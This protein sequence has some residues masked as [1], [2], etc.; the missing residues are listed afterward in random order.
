MGARRSVCG[1]RSVMHEKLV[2][3]PRKKSTVKKV[4]NML[5]FVLACVS[6][7]LAMF[8]PIIF[9]IPAVI[10][11]ALWYFQSF[12]GDIEYEYTYFDGEFRFAKIKAKRKRK[13]LGMVSMEDVITIAP[14]GDRSV[15]KYENDSNLTYK[16]LTSG[17][18]GA[19]VYELVFKGEKGINRYEIEPDEDMLDEVMVKYPRIVIK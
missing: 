6:F 7:V 14:K 12:R 1:K 19:K 17:D 2:I 9:L 16:D 11:A 5:W 4:L 3:V 18:S 8:V 10:F 15:Y 13:G